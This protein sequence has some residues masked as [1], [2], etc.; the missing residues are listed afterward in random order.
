MFLDRVRALTHRPDGRDA[1]AGVAIIT[2]VGVSAVVLIVVLALA[3]AAIFAAGF[4]TET[5]ASVQARAAA[6]AGIDLAWAGMK[7]GT[8]YC[9]VPASGTDQF[10]T[11]VAYFDE[12][13]A[14]LPCVGVSGLVG[15]PVKAIV[16]SLGT[17][18][19]LGVAGANNGDQRR[20]TAI[21]DVVVNTNSVDLDK[22]VFSDAGVSMSNPV[23]IT[24]DT[25]GNDAD[26]YSNGNVVCANNGPH[27]EGS[28]F[29]QGD[30]T[31]NYLCEIEGSVWTG[32]VVNITNQVVVNGDLMAQGGT[33]SPAAAINLDTTF[34]KGSV[35]SNG[36]VNLNGT[37]N[38][39][40]CALNGEFAKVCGNIYSLEGAINMT[41]DAR[42]GG[43]LY[44]Y[45]SVNIGSPNLTTVVWGSVVSK[46]GGLLGNNFSTNVNKKNIADYLAIAGT[47]SITNK[48]IGNL[49]SSC[50]VGIAGISVCNP[51]QPSFSLAGAPAILNFPTNSRVVA[52]PRESLP[53][54]NLYPTA[55]L[56]SR[57]PGW[58]IQAVPCADWRTTIGSQTPGSKVVMYLTGCTDPV[59]LR[60]GGNE[61]LIRGD[62]ALMAESGFL[63]SNPLKIVSAS[64]TE[65][66]DFMMI[67]PSDAKL[68]DGTTPLVTWETP[69]VTDPD[70]SRP[71][72]CPATNY[73]DISSIQINTIERLKM[74]LYTP[75]Q[76][77]FRDPVAG[78]NGQIYSGDTVFP[79]NS[80]F[81]FD[82][83]D[84][85][86]AT[87]GT[88]GG[89]ASYD[90][91]LTARFDVAD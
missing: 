31:S 64:L 5:R 82:A 84:V 19:S 46:T 36:T 49:P 59:D 58:A 34:V 6:D 67:V 37:T 61:L 80:T 29:A 86:G 13:G 15:T 28:I 51:A 50:A 60:D 63:N 30:F 27:V 9:T 88:G 21:F 75:C 85:P 74:F 55:G 3:S 45:G 25:G 77:E 48:A 91:T 52:P 81:N 22:A 16:N 72:G 35:V 87:S 78:F 79:A 1:Q 12:D 18:T 71:T 44:G 68:A 69:I 83:V 73:G 76:V 17:A 56:G 20:V 38:Q 23:D 41:G 33:G 62:L 54:I 89:G 32:G 65:T 10:A 11:T 14:A 8:F 2:V 7:Q 39:Q 57:W 40:R 47:S 42:V 4:T 66:Y 43:S 26:I 70:Y 24:D 90:A 53:R